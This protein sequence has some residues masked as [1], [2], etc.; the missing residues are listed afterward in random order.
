MDEKNTYINRERERAK[1][2]LFSEFLAHILFYLLRSSYCFS[3]YSCCEV[4]HF[5]CLLVSPCLCV[6]ACV[7]V[8]VHVFFS[9]Y[10]VLHFDCVKFKIEREKNLTTKCLKVCAYFE[11][12]FME[13][14]PTI[15]TK[16][17]KIWAML[18]YLQF[19]KAN[20]TK[21]DKSKTAKTPTPTT[22]KILSKP[23][24]NRMCYRHECMI[25]N[26]NHS[27]SRTLNVLHITSYF[28]FFLCHLFATHF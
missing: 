4:F 13:L 11:K 12:Y 19:I 23:M 2:S 28:I 27:D 25:D 9:S 26:G 21:H 16:R 22:S 5:V 17:K 7:F 6:C 18:K 15:R 14:C 10:T 20:G 3:I 8:S 1:W 24:A